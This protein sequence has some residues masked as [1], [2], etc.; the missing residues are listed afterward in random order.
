MNSLQE[1]LDDYLS[2]RR[3]VGFKLRETEHMLRDY[4]AYLDRREATTTTTDLALTWAK[5]PINV[6]PHRW[7]QRLTA[8][9]GFAK[10][11][12]AL[13]AAAEVPPANLLVAQR[14]RT[15]PYIYSELEVA[16][17]LAGAA[18]LAPPFRAVTYRTLLGLLAVTGM[19]VGE[20]IRLDC[21]DVNW[22]DG[23]LTVRASKFNRSREVVL[24]L[25]AA[26]VFAHR[27]AEL[28][29]DGLAQLG[30]HDAD[31]ERGRRSHGLIRASCLAGTWAT[32][33][34]IS[35]QPCWA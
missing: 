2:I 19:R 34:G 20:A 7:H 18:T 29:D 17:L 33:G 25:L 15:A 5:Q 31:G 13:D 6:A 28:D 8:V 12:H 32:A 26:A 10:Y 16:A 14:A 30:E 24:H 4:V 35:D 9:R 21:Q 3:S 27:R 22:T 1:A 11:L 23:L